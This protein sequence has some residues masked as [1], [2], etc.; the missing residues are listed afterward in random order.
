MRK[1]EKNEKENRITKWSFLFLCLLFSLLEE[2]MAIDGDACSSLEGDA[3]LNR[4]PFTLSCQLYLPFCHHLLLFP[5]WL[6]FPDHQVIILGANLCV[7]HSF[8]RILEMIQSS[9]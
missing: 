9:T 5:S 4:W 2:L 3:T 1:R 6:L 7:E 8:P